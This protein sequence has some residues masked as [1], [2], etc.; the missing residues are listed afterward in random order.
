[1]YIFLESQNWFKSLVLHF[2]MTTIGTFILSLRF[3][4][5]LW[6]SHFLI[7]QLQFPLF[8]ISKNTLIS[9]KFYS[10]QYDLYLSNHRMLY[11]PLKIS[12]YFVPKGI[13]Q[14]IYYP[15]VLEIGQ[16]IWRPE[17]KYNLW[18][19]CFHVKFVWTSPFFMV[20][21]NIHKVHCNLL[22]GSL[23]LHL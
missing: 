22:L 1:M 6:H 8:F 17:L 14:F 16:S 2:T 21:F 7:F 3:S 11:R 10:F 15:F 5:T 13:D 4:F 18:Q 20:T 12:L 23:Y 19:P 9:L